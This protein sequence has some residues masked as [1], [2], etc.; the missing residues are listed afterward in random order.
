MRCARGCRPCVGGGSP[1]WC[2]RLSF[3]V[4]VFSRLLCC[5]AQLH[6]LVVLQMKFHMRKLETCVNLRSFSN[7]SVLLHFA[8]SKVHFE[9]KRYSRTDYV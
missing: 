2:P 7:I 9:K 4:G 8:F 3:E 5:L 1:I 6:M